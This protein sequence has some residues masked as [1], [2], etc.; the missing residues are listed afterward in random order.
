[1]SQT[2]NN[3]RNAQMIE[4]EFSKFENFFKTYGILEEF[5]KMQ[6]DYMSGVLQKHTYLQNAEVIMSGIEIL[7]LAETRDNKNALIYAIKSFMGQ[8]SDISQLKQFL[9]EIRHY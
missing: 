6:N 8:K 5:Q 2:I 4:T 3:E 1:M 9:A 7:N